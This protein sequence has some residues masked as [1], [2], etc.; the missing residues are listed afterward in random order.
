MAASP[1]GCAWKTATSPCPT[2]RASASRANRT[3]T[4]R[5]APWPNNTTKTDEVFLLLFIH[6]KK[7]VLFSK[8]N[9]KT[10]IRFAVYVAGDYIRS[11]HAYTAQPIHSCIAQ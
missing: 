5:C 3:Y 2:C 9:Q 10:F 8:K 11:R 6:K 1:T 4:P 7:A